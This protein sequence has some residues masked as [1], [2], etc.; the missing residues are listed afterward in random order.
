MSRGCDMNYDL[1]LEMSLEWSHRATKEDGVRTLCFLSPMKYVKKV[2]QSTCHWKKILQT[3][4]KM[5]Y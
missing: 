1:S 4:K 5:V 2:E 3:S